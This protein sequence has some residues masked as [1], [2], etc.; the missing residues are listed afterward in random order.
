MKILSIIP[1]KQNVKLNGLDARNVEDMH[2]MFSSCAE[3]KKLEIKKF[4]T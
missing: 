4:K 1:F 2:D 3:L